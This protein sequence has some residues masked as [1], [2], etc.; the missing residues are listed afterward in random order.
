MSEVEKK[1]LI[2]PL[3]WGYGHAA[4]MLS[5][6]RWL[7]EENEVYVAVPK[8]LQFFF[9]KEDVKII[10]LPGLNIR[11]NR[12]PLLLS[13]FFQLPKILIRL[14]FTRIIIKKAIKK[15][16][17]NF[18]ISDNHPLVFHK[19][20]PSVYI[21]HQLNIQHSN[22]F[23]KKA[24]NFA[25]HRFIQRFNEC[26]VPD[27]EKHELAGRLS[28]NKLKIPIKYIGGIS[29]FQTTEEGKSKTF[30]KV[31]ILSGPEPE[32]TRWAIQ[33]KKVWKNEEETLII[34]L[35]SGKDRFVEQG[36]LTL[37]SHLNDGLFMSILNQ[38]DE[39][40]SRSGYSTIMDLSYL[41]KKGTFI[42]TK[43]QTEQEYL[44]GYYDHKKDLQKHYFASQTGVLEQL[45]NMLK[46]KL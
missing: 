16:G 23:I 20:I 17:I 22:R 33:M 27:T 12:M 24:I 46:T 38:A 19:R 45:E 42:P 10:S 35:L 4:R 29:R 5:I 30:K 1:I 34:G 2:V 14:L 15:T 3:D 32:K 25:H 18:I 8:S 44:A 26:W 7:S 28:Q 9:E 41:G 40:I 43:G 21:T 36:A 11:F 37:S 6:V 39:I 31:C 13:M